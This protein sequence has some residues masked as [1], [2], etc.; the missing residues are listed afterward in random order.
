MSTFP[1]PPAK[2]S[3][4]FLSFKL[5]AAFPLI[6]VEYIY[7]CAHIIIPKYT[8]TVNVAVDTGAYGMPL[9]SCVLMIYFYLLPIPFCHRISRLGLDSLVG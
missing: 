5:V 4:T 8:N 6:V 3:P 9:M 1:S 2:P 7:V